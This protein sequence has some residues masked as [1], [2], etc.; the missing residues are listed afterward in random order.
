MAKALAMNRVI[1]LLHEWLPLLASLSGVVVPVYDT[2]FDD[3][4]CAG[5]APDA[6]ASDAEFGCPLSIDTSTYCQLFEATLR[7]VPIQRG[8]ASIFRVTCRYLVLDGASAG[9]A[10]SRCMLGDAKSRRD[11][12]A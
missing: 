10:L 5:G 11:H 7:P 12:L 8:T 1:R 9:N 6:R 4:A 2:R 3:E